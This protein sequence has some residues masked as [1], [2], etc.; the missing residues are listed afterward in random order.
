M[1]TVQPPS[2]PL[3]V[4]KLDMELLSVLLAAIPTD[5]SVVLG[6]G[7][8]CDVAVVDAGG[9]EYLLLKSDPITFAT[10]EIGH[11]A[12]T[13]NVN[14]I[15]TAG[16]T[17]RWFL[18]TLLLPEGGTTPELVTRIYGELTAACGRYGATLVGGHTEVTHGL[19]RPLFCGTLVGT[20]SRDGLVTNRG[21]QVGD[22][23][24]VT[25]G[26]AVEGTS[27]LAREC[28]RTLEAAGVSPEELACFAGYLHDPG[29]GVLVEAKAACGCARVHAMHDPTE[30][31][32][33]TGLW[34]MALAS[35]IGLRV[36]ASAIPVLDATRRL[37]G[38]LGL[39]PLGLIASGSLALAVAPRDASRVIAAC[40]GVG[41]P[42]T[43]IG[44]AVPAGDGCALVTA[45]GE[46]PL[47]RYDQDEITRA[48]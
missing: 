13:V 28:G 8:G 22:A 41:V 27:I 19:D 24:L 38:V 10:D 33:A 29:I 6:P 30:G 11:Y 26:I 5:A 12:V 44:M 20:V 15:A 32:L 21:A 36:D 31:G 16:G 46:I 48:L 4:G 14:D 25:K 34:E 45:T 1:S 37:C 9:D 2:S 40:R 23:I 3:P 7:I 35:G 18:G 47:P 43:Q 17:P 42:C 39:D